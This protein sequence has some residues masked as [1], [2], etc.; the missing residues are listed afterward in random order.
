[1]PSGSRCRTYPSC[2]KDSI[3]VSIGQ[4]TNRRAF[5]CAGVNDFFLCLINILK[6]KWA[7]SSIGINPT[8]PLGR[9]VCENFIKGNLIHQGD[10]V[11]DLDEINEILKWGGGRG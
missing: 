10:D 3:S 1:M 5:T 11:N 9:I 2:L 6:N 7:W 8:C 4:P